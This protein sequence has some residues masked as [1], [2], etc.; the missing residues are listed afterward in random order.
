MSGQHK[1]A[2]DVADVFA[3]AADNYMAALAYYYK[4]HFFYINLGDCDEERRS[5]RMLYRS[6]R[7]VVNMHI[8]PI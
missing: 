5:N 8:R 4:K 3:L 6:N 2:R 7:K 1:G